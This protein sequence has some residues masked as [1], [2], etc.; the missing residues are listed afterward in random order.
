MG[1][2][3][4]APWLEASLASY[5]AASDSRPNTDPFRIAS[6]ARLAEIAEERGDWGAAVQNWQ[7]IVDAGGKPEWTE[8]ARARIAELQS[9]QLAGG[10]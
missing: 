9:A 8:M 5:E 3:K 6:L 10:S 2:P 7:A 1:T 4:P